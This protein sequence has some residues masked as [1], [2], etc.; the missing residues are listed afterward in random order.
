M[1]CVRL[2]LALVGFTAPSDPPGRPEPEQLLLRD[3]TRAVT[4]QSLSDSIVRATVEGFIAAWKV[5]NVGRLRAVMAPEGQVVWLTGAGDST[6]VNAMPFARPLENRRPQNGPYDLVQFRDVSIV[7]DMMAS[8]EVEI[9]I[10]SG[11]Y[12]DRYSL[13]KAGRVWQIATKT[14]VQRRGNGP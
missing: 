3:S 2:L 14:Y 4:R 5:G 12:I 7:D 6:R 11:S 10:A 9:R 13:Y 1:T 8:V